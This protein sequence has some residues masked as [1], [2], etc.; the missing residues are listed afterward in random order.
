M[1][2]HREAID[3]TIDRVA[4]GLTLV[5]ADPELPR[6]ITARVERQPRVP[7]AWR[8]AIGAAATAAAAMLA[9]FVIN[10][11]SS[12]SIDRARI[13]DALSVS[14]Q[15]RDIA[16]TAV[17]APVPIVPTGDRVTRVAPV[18][19]VPRGA[20]AIEPLPEFRQIDALPSPALLAVDDLNTG[21]LTLAPVDVAPLD[22]VN[23]V[24]GE[25]SARDEPKE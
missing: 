13:A 5:A 7:F 3:D 18:R 19:S 2:R 21:L 22:L 17:V 10:P 11:P 24:V 9:A 16:P 14:V 15:S 20:S 23:L 8:L 4:A 6:R 12:P 1:T 25:V